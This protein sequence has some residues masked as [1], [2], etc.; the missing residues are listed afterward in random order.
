MAKSH[1]EGAPEVVAV[2]PEDGA[3]RSACAPEPLRVDGFNTTAAIPY[4]CTI[5]QIR[6]TMQEF[7]D[8]LGFINAQLNSRSIARFE[9]MLSPA[10]FSSMVGEFAVSTL[11]KH[12]PTLVANRFH[13]GHPDLLP[14]GLF[15]GEAL[16]HGAEG[17]EVKGSRYPRGWQG[18]NPEDC[19]LMVFV[20]DASRPAD[21]GKNVP[22]RSF[23]FRRV[24]LG[25]LVKSDWTFSGRKEGSR[26]TITASVNPS[27]Y[28]KMT[29]NWVYR[30]ENSTVTR[31]RRTGRP[32][33]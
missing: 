3:E 33:A 25:R 8:F 4:D 24:Y 1:D 11:P 32:A 14:A 30:S 20:F 31:P 15:P 22:P 17:I 27:G 18:H 12:C 9:S 16:Q 19:W 28:A 29:A 26:R 10:N 21:R 6:R 2:S 5:D 7:L 13:N 23:G